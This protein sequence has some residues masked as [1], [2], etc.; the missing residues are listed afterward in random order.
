LERSSCFG[1]KFSFAKI[2]F[3][4]IIFDIC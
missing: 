4:N 2:S 1:K 3:F